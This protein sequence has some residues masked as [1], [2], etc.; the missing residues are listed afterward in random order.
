M[1]YYV[2]GALVVA[3]ELK[4]ASNVLSLFKVDQILTLPSNDKIQF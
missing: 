4:E 2:S 3:E 1:A